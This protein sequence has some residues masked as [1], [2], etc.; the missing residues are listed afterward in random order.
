MARDVQGK[1]CPKHFDD[2]SSSNGIFNLQVT[3][4]VIRD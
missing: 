1:F 3:S 2:P 4:V